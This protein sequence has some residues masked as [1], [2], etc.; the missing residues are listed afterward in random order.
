[1]GINSI[2]FNQFNQLRSGWRFAIFLTAF[3][4]LAVFLGMLAQTLLV[5]TA[6]GYIPG[7]P[8]F[9]LVNGAA[10]LVP[11]ILLGWL[12]GKFL[13]GVPFRALGVSFTE[14]WL[15]HLGLGLLIGTLTVGFAVL[16][17]VVFGGL[18][19]HIN[20]STGSS[21]ILTT[22]LISLLVFAVAA[23]FEEALFRGYMLQTFSRAGL[24]WLSIA[25]TSTFFAAVHYRNPN[26]GTLSVFNTALA[27]V[28]FGIAYLKTRDLWFVWGMHLMWNWIQGA[29][30][31][32]EVS[33]LTEV[34]AAPLLMEIDRGPIWLTGENYGIEGGI[35]TTVALIVSIFVIYFLPI[36]KPSEEMLALTSVENAEARTQ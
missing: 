6:Y 1:M 26:A 25:L 5:F 2:F 22:L 24:A 13:D 30:F 33:G 35:V 9:L 31:G 11:A 16:L 7:S 12:C 14:Y 17:A 10:S 20:P 4:F 28:W 21:E 19:F 15:R 27:G 3:V 34:T 18:S 23:A 36:L 29:F 8:A 32:I